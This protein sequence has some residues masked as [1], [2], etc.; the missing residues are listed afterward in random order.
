MT[1][2]SLALSSDPSH[3]RIFEHMREHFKSSTTT[4]NLPHVPPSGTNESLKATLTLK[5]RSKGT[6]RSAKITT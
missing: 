2:E 3:R 6:I 5:G 1:D 4:K